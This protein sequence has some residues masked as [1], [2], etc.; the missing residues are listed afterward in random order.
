MSA[1]KIVRWWRWTLTSNGQQSITISIP[2]NDHVW[3]AFKRACEYSQ[4]DGRPYPE[5]R[6]YSGWVEHAL[7]AYMDDL[8]QSP[9]LSSFFL[10]ESL[11]QIWAEKDEKKEAAQTVHSA[12]A[13]L[14][15]PG[16]GVT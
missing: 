15:P 3:R 1:L 14:L 4:N 6:M 13:E 5:E 7:E 16:E 11:Q 2:I 9:Q 8:V 10:T 12:Q